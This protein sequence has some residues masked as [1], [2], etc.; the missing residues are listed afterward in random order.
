MTKKTNNWGIA[1]I[2]NPSL[3]DREVRKTEP[4]DRLWASELGKAPVDTYLKLK[5]I[6]QTNPPNPRSLRKFE[7]GNIWEWIVSLILSRAGILQDAQKWTSYQYEEMLPVTGRLDFYAGG[8]PDYERATRELA[9][10]NLPGVFLRASKNIVDTLSK[11]YPD[12]LSTK[13]IEVKSTSSFMFDSYERNKTSSANHRMQLFHYL[14]AENISEGLL[15]Y[16][17]KDDCRMLE[18]PV[19][20]PSVVEDE[21]KSNIETI[22]KYY[23][24]NEQPPL[25]KPIEFDSDLMKF[26]KNWKIAYS[27]YL[28]HLYGFKNQME[29][30]NKYSPL[31]ERWN[32]VLGRIADGKDMTDNNKAALEEMTKA[33]FEVDKIKEDILAANINK[34]IQTTQKT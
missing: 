34:T 22:S 12:G 33:G 3:L 18:I 28:T 13:I 27:G 16:I 15:M 14:K 5:G 25:E 19:K 8:K 24:A 2:W 26:S 29:F 30:D 31:V 6:E 23:Y 20:N 9:Q 21:Y 7:A 32:R 17:C 11:Q 10:L 1:G 4:R